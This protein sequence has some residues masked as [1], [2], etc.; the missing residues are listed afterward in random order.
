MQQQYYLTKW[1]TENKLN[2]AFIIT[3]KSINPICVASFMRDPMASKI[4]LH[5]K[6][7]KS[8]KIAIRYTY[9]S[10]YVVTHC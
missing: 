2:W 7:A 10:I 4:F 8:W 9:I 1:G 5:K 3:A 6:I